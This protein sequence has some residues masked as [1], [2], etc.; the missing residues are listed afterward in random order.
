VENKSISVYLLLSLAIVVISI[1][2]P[3]EF[4]KSYSYYLFFFQ[5]IFFYMYL[6]RY[7]KIFLYLTPIMLFIFYIDFSFTLGNYAMSHGHEN[8]KSNYYAFLNWKNT[9]L[10]TSFILLLNLSLF[11]LDIIFRKKYFEILENVEK[12]EIPNHII[13][14]YL[15]FSMILFFFFFFLPLNTNFLG[16]SGDLS[17]IPKAIAMLS[18]IYI[19]AYKRNKYR[20]LYYILIIAIFALFSFSSKREAIFF[21]FP[22]FLIESLLNYMTLNIKIIFVV[23]MTTIVLIIFI[24][25]MSITRGYGGFESQNVF[26]SLFYINSYVNSDMFLTYFFKNIE[27]SY[28]Y[29]HSIQAMEYIINDSTLIT[30]GSTFIKFLFII[31]P[32]SISDIKPKSFIDIYTTYHDPSFRLLGGSWPPNLI[33]EI[34]WNF[35]YFGLIFVIILFYGINIFF[36]KILT[37]IRSGNIL[38]RPWILFIYILLLVFY[39]GGGLDICII[40]LIFSVFF[41]LLYRYVLILIPYK[42]KGNNSYL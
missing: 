32:S 6:Y 14:F 20:Y 23:V 37:L 13:K 34:F 15:V 18:I 2:I 39:R 30:Y 28:T 17:Y 21:I 8:I 24:L 16:G 5:L 10:I 19:L 41:S 26:N 31:I 36:L 3:L 25:A 7:K 29:Y 12:I 35:Y 22:I 1:L 42:S 9:N 38:Y 4:S 40:Y 33:A 11:I 27:T